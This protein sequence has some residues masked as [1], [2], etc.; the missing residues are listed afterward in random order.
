M[1]EWFKKLI[2]G[3]AFF[4]ER[5]TQDDWE[6]FIAF[7]ARQGLAP[8][9]YHVLK[10]SPPASLAASQLQELSE[11]YLGSAHRNLILYHELGKVLR[12]FQEEGIPVIVLKGACLAKAVYENI[13]LRSMGDVDLLVRRADLGK[14]AQVLRRHGYTA[15]YDFQVENEAAIHCHLP[16]MRGSRKLTIEVHW[17]IFDFTRFAALEEEEMD[18]VWARAQPLNIENVPCLMLAPE[19]MI[20]HLCIHISRQH[21][22]DMRL[23]GFL[24]LRQVCK[25]YGETIVGDALWQRASQWRV[26]RAVALTAFLAERWVGLGLGEDSRHLRDLER[27]DPEIMAWIEKKILAE[28]SLGMGVELPEFVA[29]KSYK[30][31]LRVLWRRLFPPRAT[32]A[33]LYKINPASGIIYFFYPVRW[34]N[35]GRRFGPTVWRAWN[36]DQTVVGPLHQENALRNWLSRA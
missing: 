4:L 21:L 22:F 28:S 13:A 29:G 9:L 30:Q 10:E 5:L 23:R 31:R 19:D 14:T 27:P 1:G 24:D 33:R 36:G 15:G 26:R 3:E 8:V 20:L 32:L 7:A 6:G 34:F 16:P 12:G 11:I 18:H 17:T 25:R 35:L 2:A